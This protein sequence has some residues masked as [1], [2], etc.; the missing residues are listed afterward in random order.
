MRLQGSLEIKSINTVGLRVNEGFNN[1]TLL[2]DITLDK[3]AKKTQYYFANE[4][5]N[6]K[7]PDATTI[8]TGW[9]I[10]IFN[11]KLSTGV[12]FL[13]DFTGTQQYKIKPKKSVS[14]ILLEN[15]TQQGVWKVIESGAG[16]SGV[17]SRNVV[18]TSHDE[19]LFTVAAGSVTINPFI[20]TVS[21]GFE[22]D[23][24]HIEEIIEFTGTTALGVPDTFP[25]TKFV[26]LTLEG[27]ITKEAT[28]QSG[29]NVFPTHPEE[30]DIFYNLSLI[31]I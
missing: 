13:L 16:G 27:L 29:G 6:V 30:G 7:L 21:N 2:T 28:K 11:N 15:N 24:T 12:V 17:G 10:S 4:D 26:Y 1:Q 19:P 8:P 20:A 3:F 23:G 5:R 14:I 31:H 25:K 9:N 18:I 22:E